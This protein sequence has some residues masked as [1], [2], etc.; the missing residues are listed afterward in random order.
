MNNDCKWRGCKKCNRKHISLLHY[1]KNKNNLGETKQKNQKAK[2]NISDEN[3]GIKAIN[4]MTL[5]QVLLS[6]V[7]IYMTNKDGKRIQ[8]LVLLDSGS[9]SNFTKSS[10]SDN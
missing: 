7:P 4:A 5:T 1:E 6:T 2:S 9:K 10:V 3:L 8:G